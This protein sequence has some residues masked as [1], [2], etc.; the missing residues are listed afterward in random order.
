MCDREAHLLFFRSSFPMGI[1]SVIG[2][3]GSHLMDDLIEG[4]PLDLPASR[5]R[6]E[7]LRASGQGTVFVVDQLFLNASE[8][9]YDSGIHHGFSFFDYTSPFLLRG[10]LIFSARVLYAP[11]RLL[12]GIR[13]VG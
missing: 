8:S 2:R 6:L 9:A 12:G 1:R 7:A 3:L 5:H 10:F 13:S 11:E 4:G